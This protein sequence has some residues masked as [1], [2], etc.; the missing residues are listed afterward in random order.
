M[1]PLASW[2]EML[3]VF[4]A[5]LAGL[6]D[7][8][9]TAATSN[10][11]STIA[12]VEDRVALRY[13]D[14]PG[15]V[16]QQVMSLR[17]PFTKHVLRLFADEGQPLF[18]GRLGALIPDSGSPGIPSSGSAKCDAYLW[19]KHRYLDCGKCS[20]QVMAY[21]LD[22][23]WLKKSVSVSGLSNNTL[24]NH[25]YFIANRDFFFDLGMWE[26]GGPGR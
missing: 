22:A 3:Q 2:E 4:Q 16:C 5:Q 21:Y 1:R 26:E 12:G 23:Y 11:A 25:D 9:K 8:R 14:R 17:L 7:T 20:S 10:L 15:S 18:P 6:V 24:V 19:A 13:D